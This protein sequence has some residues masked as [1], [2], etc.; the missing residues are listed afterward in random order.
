ML[1]RKFIRGSSETLVLKD[2]A[3]L[4][5][6]FIQ[7]RL[8]LGI[9]VSEEYVQLRDRAAI[10]PVFVSATDLGPYHQLVLL[11]RR[12]DG[13]RSLSDLRNKR[14]TLARDQSKTIHL[15]WLETLLMKEGA[16]RAEDFFSSVKE[17]RKSSQAILPVFFH[18]ADACLT[19][20][21]SF[22]VVRELNPQVG[23]DL[24]VLAQSRDIAGGVLA[25]RADYDPSARETIT[26]VLR[27]LQEDPQGSQLLKLFRMSRLIPWKPEYITSAEAL[28]R[29]HGRL[30]LKLTPERLR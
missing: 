4:E 11:V 9:M 15:F 12:R 2:V 17:V 13:L 27:T 3:S 25:F 14:L 16:R 22:D 30:R 6:A 21:Q 29:E 23:E 5:S 20:Q 18:Q 1:K 7:K 19:T 8:D 24:V 26:E 10:L 28:L